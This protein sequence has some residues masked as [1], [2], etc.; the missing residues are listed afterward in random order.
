MFKEWNLGCA[1]FRSP[2]PLDRSTLL[3]AADRRWGAGVSVARRRM[4]DVEL[5]LSVDCAEPWYQIVV[6]GGFDFLTLDGTREQNLATACWLRSLMPAD[7]QIVAFGSG[8]PGVVPLPAG[9]EPD[10]LAGLFPAG[11]PLDR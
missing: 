2:L 1:D 6:M 9:A 10:A 8:G 3:D 4:T 11:R 7:A 5:R